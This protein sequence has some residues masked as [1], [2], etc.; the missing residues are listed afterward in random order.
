M[1]IITNFK[2]DHTPFE[3]TNFV[4][5]YNKSF[6][7]TKQITK[8][9]RIYHPKLSSATVNLKLKMQN[10]SKIIK[11]ITIQ[12]LILNYT[13]LFIILDSLYLIILF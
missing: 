13:K 3:V 2:F 9:Y 8:L 4:S 11:T 7:I 10:L 12:L 1:Y 6:M 5:D